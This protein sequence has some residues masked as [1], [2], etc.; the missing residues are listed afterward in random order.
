[1]VNDVM[2]GLEV[3]LGFSKT[4]GWEGGGQEKLPC[5]RKESF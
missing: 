4:A 3:E 5:S 1:M 2:G